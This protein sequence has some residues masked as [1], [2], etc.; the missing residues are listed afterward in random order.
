M[1]KKSEPVRDYTKGCLNVP[2]GDS[3]MKRSY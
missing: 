3:E 1:F 2:S